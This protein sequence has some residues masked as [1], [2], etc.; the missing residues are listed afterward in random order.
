[1]LQEKRTI[2]NL[3]DFRYKG[4]RYK[5]NGSGFQSH[6]GHALPQ[7]FLEYKEAEVLYEDLT[8][9]NHHCHIYHDSDF[10]C[11]P[12]WANNVLEVIYPRSPEEL[13][14]MHSSELV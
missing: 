14:F 2:R 3:T 6:A 1:M 12:R 9:K 13:P 10:N 8:E 7:L 5:N 4:N 11:P